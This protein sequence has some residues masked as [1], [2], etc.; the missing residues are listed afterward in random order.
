[1][2][3]N[4][5]ISIIKILACLILIGF[6]YWNCEDN[7]AEDCAGIIGG[8]SVEDNCGNCD[9]DNSN[10]C[11][12]DCA[13]N[14]GGDALVDEC[15]TC[16]SN[17]SND[18]TQDCN[19]IWGGKT[20]IDSCGICNGTGELTYYMDDEGDGYGNCEMVFNHC[21]QDSPNG[22][23]LECSDCD[24]ENNL[25]WE[26]DEC[27]ICGGTGKIKQC[28]DNDSKTIRSIIGVDK[29]DDTKETKYILTGW[30][31]Y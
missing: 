10:D 5:N 8:N 24:D 31:D 7:Q 27:G 20:S 16:D 6:T 21:P 26:L 29:N 19:G 12:E 11:V 30:V 1:M 23:V 15:G 9:D 28:Y 22:L 25:I 4:W 2:L 3:R 17:S 18:C 13:G 14:W